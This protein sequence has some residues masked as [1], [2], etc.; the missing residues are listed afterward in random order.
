MNEYLE[1]KYERVFGEPWLALEAGV[2]ARHPDF[3][4]LYD[5]LGRLEE[6]KPWWKFWG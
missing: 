4:E 5:A 6:V 2:R 1:K 3:F